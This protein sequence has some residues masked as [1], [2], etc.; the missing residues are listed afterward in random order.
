MKEYRKL[1]GRGTRF[2]GSR[3]I[4]GVRKSC[5]MWLAADHL[6]LIF[7][8]HFCQEFKRFY[9]RDI[10][11]LTVRK[12]DVARHW[13][14]VLGVLAGLFALIALAVKDPIGSWILWGCFAFWG[15]LA[16]INA[17]RGPSCIVEIKTAAQTEELS[18]LKRLRNARKTLSI[19]RPLI[20]E[21]QGKL[22][23]EEILTQAGA[24][25]QRAKE[26]PDA[27]SSVF[28]KGVGPLKSCSARLHQM[29]FSLL[30]FDGILNAINIYF[31]PVWLLVVES[32]LALSLVAIAITALIKQQETDLTEGLR[33]I[34]WIATG[35]IVLA[36]FIAVG[37]GFAV[38]A[39]DPSISQDQWAMFQRVSEL[40][41]LETPW[42]FGILLFVT[43]CSIILGTIGIV[44]AIKFRTQKMKAAI[45]P[46]L[47]VTPSADSE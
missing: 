25:L 21:A 2:E 40:D 30:L 4:A 45:P 9:L 35:Y 37:V 44:L 26:N 36:H 39:G 12:T 28:L 43:L 10:Q 8:A 33:R 41:P 18:S 20:D 5:T 46:L 7:S 3:L 31:H 16:L 22:T 27:L 13:T 29:L 11:A 47:N 42:L 6:L 17:V 34:T 19:L 32:L 15:V 1:P 24:A 38:A 14:I 23:A